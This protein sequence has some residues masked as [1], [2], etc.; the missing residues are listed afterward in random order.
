MANNSAIEWTEATWNPIVGCS[1]KSP[2]C[3]HCYAMGEAARQIRCAAGLGRE[4]HYA[5][6]VE[7]VKGK[8]VWTGELRQAPDSILTAPLRRKKPTTYFVNSMGDLFH[9]D[10]PDEWIDRVFAVMALC[11]QHTF[12]VLTKRAA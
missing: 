8:P 9:E 1:L 5:G 3:T 12:Q 10:C 4:T 11:P 2:G 6:T 7:I